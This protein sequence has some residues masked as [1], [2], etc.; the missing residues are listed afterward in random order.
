MEFAAEGFLNHLSISRIAVHIY[1]MVEAAHYS[2]V[3]F[4]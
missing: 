3:T 1:K 4:V 2:K